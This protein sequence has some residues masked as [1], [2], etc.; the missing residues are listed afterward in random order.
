MKSKEDK[1]ILAFVILVILFMLSIMYVYNLRGQLKS[2]K[3]LNKISK[4]FFYE[5]LDK[6]KEKNKLDSIQLANDY[7]L[8]IGKLKSKIYLRGQNINN[9]KNEIEKLSNYKTDSTY[10]YIN[11]SIFKITMRHE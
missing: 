2:E 6:Q 3:T 1:F 10:Q 4:E 11:D 7:D 9:L 8:I 5:Q